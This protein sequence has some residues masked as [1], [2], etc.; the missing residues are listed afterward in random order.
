[1]I[2]INELVRENIKTLIPYS[3]AREEYR[4]KKG[5]FLDANENPLGSVIDPYF[6]KERDSWNRYPDPLHSELREKIGRLK[7]VN[8]GNIFLGNGS[9]EAIDLPIRAFCEPRIDKI[10]IMPPTYGMYQVCADI[11]DVELVKVP[12]TKE[13]EIN[14][15]KVLLSLEDKKIKLIYLCS[16][17]NPTGNCLDRD[18]IREIL[19]KFKGLVIIDEAYIDFSGQISWISELDNFNNLIVLQTFSKVWGLAGIRLG[20][21]FSDQKVI[22]ILDKIKYPYNINGITQRLAIEALENIK[23][24]ENMRN[25]ILKQKD[26]LKKDLLQLEVIKKVYPSDANFFLVKFH[27]AKEVYQYLLKNGVIVRDRSQV[28]HC[29]NCLRITVGTCG[30]N[31]KLIQLLK[32]YR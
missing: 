31:K 14:L 8:Q 27:N 25:K 1:M 13:F 4:G 21:A 32:K 22:R 23:N 24:K 16:P 11:N 20:I 3:S 6:V 15:E 5:V 26:K 30:E 28:I 10:M 19:T 18:K 7:S 29:D 12:L 2:D 17:N 9:D